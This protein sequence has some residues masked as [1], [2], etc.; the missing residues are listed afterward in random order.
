MVVEVEVEFCDTENGGRGVD[1]ELGGTDVD[2]D[3]R[4]VPGVTARIFCN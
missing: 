3:G 1:N 2:A 4:G